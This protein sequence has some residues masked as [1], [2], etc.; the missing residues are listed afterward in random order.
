MIE[1]R[2]KMMREPVKITKTAIQTLK[3]KYG[4]TDR[5]IRTDHVIRVNIQNQNLDIAIFSNDDDKFPKVIGEIKIGDFVFPFAEY[6]LEK[7]MNNSNAKYGFLTNGVDWINYKIVNKKIIK[8]PTISSK[9]TSQNKFENTDT[10]QKFT[11]LTN[12]SDIIRK[13]SRQSRIENHIS[14][15]EFLQLIFFKIYDEKYEKNK[16]FKKISDEPS[17]CID[18]F[19]TL[20]KK[21]NKKFPGLFKQNYLELPRSNQLLT[22]IEMSSYSI[23]KADPISTSNAL[24]MSLNHNWN[25]SRGSITTPS[26]LVE[27]ID[28]LEPILDS[29]KILIPYSGPDRCIQI[30]QLIFSKFSNKFKGEITVIEPELGNIRFLRIISELRLPKFN[31]IRGDPIEILNS[32]KSKEYDHVISIPPMGMKI[33]KKYNFEQKH[34]EKSNIS[35][36]ESE[37]LGND[38]INHFFNRLISRFKIGVKFS[39]IVPQGFLFKQSFSSDSIRRQILDNCSIKAIISLSRGTFS[40]SGVTS[41]LLLLEKG[42]SNLDTYDIFMAI[43]SK[44]G[45]KEYYPEGI[46]RKRNFPIINPYLKNVEQVSNLFQ[47]FIK[48]KSISKPNQSGFTV[49]II[50]IQKDGWT[51]TDKIPEIKLFDI[52]DKHEIL[53]CVE[54]I[55]GTN[56]PFKRS[57]TG[58]EFNF[59]KISD[60][61]NNS[62]DLKKTKKIFLD[63]NEISKIKRFLIKKDDVLFSCRGTIGKKLLVKNELENCI[64]SS[65]LMILRPKSSIIHPEYLQ[66]VLDKEIVKDQ[67]SGL[68]G[69]ISIPMISLT[70]YSRIIIPVPSLSKQKEITLKAVKSLEEISKIEKLLEETKR[71]YQEL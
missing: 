15:D 67:I 11:Q 66:Y 16:Y 70:K 36:A 24:L 49:N 32:D 65:N 33:Q 60:F 71:K 2:N 20:W 21:S 34:D 55:R 56:I 29:N 27:L 37:M 57:S 69:G 35:D 28:S 9:I 59:I 47:E 14:L 41:A 68:S 17:S 51:V 54:I 39:I 38:S 7:Y 30:L 50:E 10:K 23:T 58:E 64:A 12:S 48:N 43:L 46:G 62:L 13:I 31:I 63:K 1:K 19:Q 8:I 45:L 6:Q 18:A 5:Q 25:Y 42:T 44:P 61:N 52:P 22:I 4:Y 3:K 26:E 53:E 40:N